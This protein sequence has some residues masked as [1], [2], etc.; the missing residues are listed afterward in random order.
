MA[1]LYLYAVVIYVEVKRDHIYSNKTLFLLK[2]VILYFCCIYSVPPHVFTNGILL[3]SNSAT[4]GSVNSLSRTAGTQMNTAS[5]EGILMLSFWAHMKQSICLL[6]KI[7]KKKEKKSTN[8]LWSTYH[9]PWSM[10]QS[11]LKL[12]TKPLFFFYRWGNWES[13]LFR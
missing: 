10:K 12:T 2:R 13:N 5:N 1:F 6:F 7:L 8:I 9:A 11:H 3:K 4:V